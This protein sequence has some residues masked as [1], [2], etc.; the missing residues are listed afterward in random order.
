MVWLKIWVYAVACQTCLAQTGGGTNTSSL[1]IYVQIER[2]LTMFETNKSHDLLWQINLSLADLFNFGFIS[3][4]EHVR[5]Y[6][7]VMAMIDSNL[8]VNF[9]DT[10]THYSWHVKPPPDG[11]NGIQYPPGIAPQALKDTVARSNYEAAIVENH[12]KI[13]KANLQNDLSKLDHLVKHDFGRFLDYYYTS[14]TSDRREIGEMVRGA[15]LTDAYKQEL[16]QMIGLKYQP[17]SVYSWIIGWGDNA[18]GVIT[19]TPHVGCSTGLVVIARAVLTNATAIAAGEAHGLALKSDGTVVAWGFNHYGQ[20]LVPGGLR[21]V[22]AVAAGRDY[23][24]ALKSDGTV[25]TWG[26]NR[27]DQTN[28]AVGLKNITAI[29]AAWNNG[30]A[31]D[32]NGVITN[33][34]KLSTLPPGPTNIVAI[35]GSRSFFGDNLALNKAGAVIEWNNRTGSVNVVLALSNVVAIAAGAGHSLAL[36]SDG[37]VFGWGGNDKGQATGLS[38]TKFPA[39]S[40]GLVTINGQVLRG[41]VAIAAGNEFS[42]A[43]KS[44]GTVAAWGDNR[45]HQTDV[46]A[47]L[48]NVVAIAAG[49]NFCLAITTN[50]AVADQFR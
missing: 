30:L 31:L 23:S 32:G 12:L 26:D 44:D 36:K 38:T 35:A 1:P 43:L 11:T 19:G 41:V 10:A 6:L 42:L 20:T 37:T 15:K 7:E 8:D 27:F 47:G 48:S 2:Q 29:S 46:P 14:S 39:S 33:F 16:F 49:D 45:W 3:R 17:S 22:K 9:D 21:N 34:G 4:K 13:E 5:V 28:A 40:S 50:K 25:M 24:V 18:G